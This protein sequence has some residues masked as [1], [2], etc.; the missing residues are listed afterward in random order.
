L[1][2]AAA[3]S[4]E[5][6]RRAVAAV[7]G[8]VVAVAALWTVSSAR[9]ASADALRVSVYGDSVLLGA[10]EEITAALPGDDVFVN[11]HENV[12]LL[13][14]LPTLEADRPGMG[15][16]VV[17]DLGYNDASE[18]TAWRDR[19]DRAAAILDGVPKVIWLDQRDFA[20]GRAQMNDELRAVAQL[21][22]NIEVVD[23]NAVVGAHPDYVYGDGIHLTPAGQTGMADVVRSRIDA[24][25]AARIAAT[26]TTLAP[27]TTSRAPAPSTRD[28]GSGTADRSVRALSA[29]GSTD[30]GDDALWLGAIAAAFVVVVVVVAVY[31]ARARARDAG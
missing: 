28:A 29:P 5:A 19:L 20:D 9:P 27:T 30:G 16:V 15:D 21:H 23:W 3:P 25:V 6:A 2:V 10:S 26:S 18:L 24:F 13:G 22:P 7:V 12:S 11:A 4:A 17:L 31:R 14:T 8:V 1:R